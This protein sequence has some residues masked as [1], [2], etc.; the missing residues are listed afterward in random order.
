MHHL[1]KDG[2]PREPFAGRTGQIIEHLQDGRVLVNFDGWDLPRPMPCLLSDLS[3]P[4]RNR[5]KATPYKA[6]TR[7]PD[8]EPGTFLLR[9]GNLPSEP[10]WGDSDTLEPAETPE[11]IAML[12]NKAGRAEI[13]LIKNFTTG[14]WY[15][16]KDGALTD[17]EQGRE[18]A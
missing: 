4:D 12:V 1:D 11:D 13:I 6:W 18:R 5:S 8:G 15:T 3:L 9:T 7:D 14:L 10:D 17:D 2:N 16:A